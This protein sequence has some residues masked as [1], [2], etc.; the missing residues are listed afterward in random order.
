[1]PRRPLRRALSILGC[2]C[3]LP[4]AAVAFAQGE[5]GEHA[6]AEAAVKELE[7][8]PKKAAVAEMIA[9]AKTAL[10]RASGM[11]SAGDEAHARLAD[12]AARTWTDA[13]REV[14]RAAEI[15]ERAA[16]SRRAASDAGARAD[17]ERALLEEA[18]AQS[19]RLRAQLEALERESKEQPAK[20]SKAGAKPEPPRPAP[21]PA[22]D[23]GAP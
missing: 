23:G 2:A 8:S 18:V 7:A 1:M 4:L 10:E 22:R 6:R 11:R 21:T 5:A 17:R 16:A 15:E 9:R 20:T 19:G 14:L 3:V 12:E 13:A